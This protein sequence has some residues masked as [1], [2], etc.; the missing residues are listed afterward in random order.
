VK[1]PANQEVVHYVTDE[2]CTCNEWIFARMPEGTHR[3][4]YCVH[5]IAVLVASAVDAAGPYRL[6]LLKKHQTQPST[7][8]ES[9]HDQSPCE[10][11]ETGR[12]D[13]Q[14]EQSKLTPILLRR[15]HRI[16]LPPLEWSA[17]FLECTVR[18]YPI[19]D[20]YDST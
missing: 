8:E 10:R 5:Q 1:S 17:F 3:V 11:M 7:E 15:M 16:T 2:F 20:P 4:K 19:G 12:D 6:R 14:P 9:G 13:S 18:H